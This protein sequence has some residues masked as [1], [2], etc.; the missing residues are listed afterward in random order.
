VY[1]ETKQRTL[2]E[3]DYV[4]A[5]PTR[6][7]AKYQTTKWLPYMIKRYILFQRHAKLE[8]L[9]HFDKVEHHHETEGKTEGKT[10]GVT[11]VNEEK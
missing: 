4:F 9:Y 5:V 7:F 3:L 10:E 6:T 11:S 2:E 8:P 1:V